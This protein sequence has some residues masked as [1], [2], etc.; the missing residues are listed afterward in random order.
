MTLRTNARIAG[1][2]FL[3][4]IAAGLASM[5]LSGQATSGAGVA[6]RLATM[7][8]HETTMGI[9]ALLG[10]VQSF[11]AL[12]LAVTLYSLT[13]E[14][15]A[16]LA[17]LGLL[18]R[19]AE[20][21][22]GSL[23]V[24]EGRALLWLAT[25]TGPDAPDPAAAQALGAYLLR[26]EVAFTATFF[27]VGSALFAWLLLRGRL[28]PVPLAWLGVVASLLL[29]AGLP[30]QLAGFLHGPVT[31]ALWLPMLL[32]ELPLAFWLIA[33]GVTPRLRS[34]ES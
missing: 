5:S 31:A 12:C 28:I 17:M 13:R 22:V 6:A 20:G 21:I 18:C 10:L 33:R 27:A 8:R 9:V 16:D 25:A 32:F 30:L 4:Y 29:V 1:A 26:G 14:E 7:S 3:V 23:S 19:A 11:S 15:D 34:R 2:T 24:P